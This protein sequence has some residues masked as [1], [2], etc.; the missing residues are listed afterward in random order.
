MQAHFLGAGI[1]RKCVNIKSLDFFGERVQFTFQKSPY[2]QTNIG[3]AFSIVCMIL[4]FSFLTIR[5]MK[6]AQG[7]DPFF[8]STFISYEDEID[9]VDLGHA[10]AIENIDPTIGTIYAYHADWYAYG[11]GRA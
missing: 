6:L 8:S 9:L 3:A 11:G 7:I 2:F 1:P 5:T 10:F 4:M